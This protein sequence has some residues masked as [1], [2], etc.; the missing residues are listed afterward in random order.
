MTISFEPTVASAGQALELVRS[1]WWIRRWSVEIL[2]DAELDQKKVLE[3]S[4]VNC[5]LYVE[6]VDGNSTAQ[7]AQ[8][9]AQAFQQEFGVAW[10][11]NAEMVTDLTA[12]R[13]AANDLY[14]F[15]RDNITE[16][17]GAELVY[18]DQGR[19]VETPVLIPH[20]PAITSR[21]SAVRA[22]FD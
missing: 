9:V 22:A 6:L 1:A 13:N 3:M 2:A 19:A 8:A 16:R 7:F 4:L 20:V 5:R 12:L 21:V 17:V 10:A 14:V 18:N 11:S 15:V